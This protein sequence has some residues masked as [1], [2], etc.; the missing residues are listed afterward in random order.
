MAGE[1]PTTTLYS[2]YVY[3]N[4]QWIQLGSGGSAT[5]TDVRVNN[6]SIVSNGVANL[7]TETAYDATSN[8]I[9]TKNDIPNV[10]NFITKDVNDLT[11]YY[12]KNEIDGKVS[13]V[14]KYKGSV[15]TYSVLPSSGLTIGDVYNVESDG[16]N[17]AWTGSA[18]DSL[19]S[20]I[21]LSNYQE[22]IDSSHK[23]SSD[24]IDDTNKTNKFVTAAEKSGWD[25]KYSKPTNG[26]PSSDL[27]SDV[28]TSLSKADTALQS[29]TYTGTIT[30]ITMNG[31]SKGTSGV[32]DL[33]TVITSH[34][35]ISGKE[36]TTNKSDSYTNS[37][38][39]TYASTKALVDGLATKQAIIDSNNKLSADLIAD[40]ET[41]KTVTA[42]EKSVWNGKQTA[43]ISGVNIKTVN[44]ESV[45][46]AGNITISG[47]SSSV[48][49]R[50]VNFGVPSTK[51]YSGLQQNYVPEREILEKGYILG[52]LKQGNVAGEGTIEIDNDGFSLIIP[53][54]NGKT[55]RIETDWNSNFS[56]TSHSKWGPCSGLTPA[57]KEVWTNGRD[58]GTLWSNQKSFTVTAYFTG[59]AIFQLYNSLQSGLTTDDIHAYELVGGSDIPIFDRDTTYAD[60]LAAFDELVS[61][62]PSYITKTQL[63]VCSD[64]S[65]H[66]YEYDFVPFNKTYTTPQGSGNVVNMPKVL[67]IG[68]VHGFEKAGIFGL[69]FFLKDLCE[70]WYKDETLD[71]LRHN[72]IFKIIPVCNPYGW[73]R[74]Q[75]LNANAVNINRNYD[76]SGFVPDATGDQAGGHTPFDQPETQVIRD[77]VS[78]NTD[79]L[80]FIDFHTNGSA[81]LTTG[82]E[83]KIN[84]ID[85]IPNQDD[86]YEF[87]LKC[88]NTHLNN[89]KAHF[90]KDYGLGLSETAEFGTLTNG[91]TQFNENFPSGD[92]WVTTKKNIIGL[93]LEGFNGFPAEAAAFSGNCLK[94]NSEIV[95]NLLKTM[96]EMYSKKE[97]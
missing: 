61:D 17:Y 77:F 34:Q 59:Y 41:N 63:D 60:M 82:Q 70:N 87:I 8:K 67:I 56:S 22:K 24:L 13:A 88:C 89:L 76:T 18:W 92:A 32:V 85:T 48:F 68:G 44:N 55:Y 20:T 21:D 84:W 62:Y 4:G 11:Y 14:Y 81:K 6:T 25:A 42:I 10:N 91:N 33:G 27:S 51:Y 23:L 58:E 50:N 90:N 80:F 45:L 65:T 72:V 31:S 35:D 7:V 30:G 83:N 75:Y 15:A 3:R 43:L 95:G 1:T 47:D 97:R 36:N 29:E 57:D 66:L 2:P 64:G 93:T 46:G 49:K 71:Y 86:Y 26:I 28:Q 37:S 53:V 38:S 52:Y 78:A 19:G 96:F 73:D 74:Y 39:T 5:A 54:E 9:A 16:Q 94:A 69:Y 40:G 79:A 12:T